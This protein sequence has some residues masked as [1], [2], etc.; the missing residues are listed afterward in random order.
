MQFP[1]CQAVG[2]KLRE[3][4]VNWFLDMCRRRQMCST[5][6]CLFCLWYCCYYTTSTF[7]Y[8]RG[9]YFKTSQS[10]P[11]FRKLYNGSNLV[12]SITE[13]WKGKL[14]C[15]SASHK[16]AERKSHL[17]WLFFPQK[18]VLNLHFQKVKVSLMDRVW[19]ARKSTYITFSES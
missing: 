9:I 11:Y 2:S 10:R 6:L 14:K 8:I 1:W 15:W 16:P 5:S 12:F 3:T 7:T 4:I 18:E 13:E 17:N 19:T